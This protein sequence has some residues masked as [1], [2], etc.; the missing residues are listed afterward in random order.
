M[1]RTMENKNDVSKKTKYTVLAHTLH[2][3]DEAC[4]YVNSIVSKGASRIVPSVK[5]WSEGKVIT[6]WV[7]TVT[8]DGISY[9]S[10]GNVSI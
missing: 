8:K 5:A 4:E 2:S 6:Q 1:Y 9:K 10:N 7:P 3:F